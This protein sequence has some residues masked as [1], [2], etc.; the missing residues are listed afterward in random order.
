MEFAEG[1]V[2]Q[3]AGKNKNDPIVANKQEFTPDEQ[4]QSVQ[5]S[6]EDKTEKSN[7]VVSDSGNESLVSEET[8]KSEIDPSTVI[9]SSERKAE[10]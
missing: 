5:G 8:I 9:A 10:A 6:T 2:G 4:R 3:L 7:S 1:Q